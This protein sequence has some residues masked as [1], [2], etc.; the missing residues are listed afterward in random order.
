M[1]QRTTPLGQA[2]EGAREAAGLSQNQAADL[3]DIPRTTFKRLVRTGAFTYP[4][5]RRIAGALGVSTQSL[6]DA[7]E[8]AA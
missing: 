4:Q 1:D 8:D 6:V 5:L 7:A 2:I 3:A